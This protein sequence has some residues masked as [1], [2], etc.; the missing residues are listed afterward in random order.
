MTPPMIPDAEA[1]IT[2]HLKAHADV[3]ALGAR[4]VGRTPSA[5]K[6]PWARLTQ[7]D[8]SNDTSSR[9][10]HLVSYLLQLDCYAGDDAMDAHDGQGEA[11]LLA[12]TVRAVLHAMPDQSHV[13]VVVTQV[14]FPSLLRLPDQDFEPAMERVVLTADV[15][16][17]AG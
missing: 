12:R 5:T 9:A 13:G 11:S 17:H 3:T 15:R 8:A 6:A 4:I 16:M 14:T 10:E 2:A 7:L 1:I